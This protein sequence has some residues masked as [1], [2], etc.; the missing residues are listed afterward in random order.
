M[1]ELLVERGAADRRLVLLAAAVAQE[2]EVVRARAVGHHGATRAVGLLGGLT[3]VVGA[4]RLG[5]DAHVDEV[6]PPRHE[7]DVAEAR[8]TAE[9]GDREGPT[10]R[11]LGEQA[12]VAPVLELGGGVVRGPED[13]PVGDA[14]QVLPVGG[15]G[16]H[17]EVEAGHLGPELHVPDAGA[18]VVH[19]LDAA[20]PLVVTAGPHDGLPGDVDAGLLH[21]VDGEAALD[22]L[23]AVL[24]HRLAELRVGGLAGED[25]DH[26]AV[27]AVERRLV[28]RRRGRTVRRGLVRSGRQRGHLLR[29][30]LTRLRGL[31]GRG[32][33][34]RRRGRGRVGLDVVRS[35]LRRRRVDLRR[36]SARRQRDR[37]DD[38]QSVRVSHDLSFSW[39]VCGW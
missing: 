17:L 6:T 37:A 9:A 4:V 32:R 11:R 14:L 7:V 39:L 30:L 23:H 10:V 25:D 19:G 20:D 22:L 8:D 31:R 29:D 12:H 26:H 21:L 27:D 16:V 13:R 18:V 35:G 24:E 38:E 28:G 33:V 15:D 36:A 3:A 34:D 5:A 2:R 1:D